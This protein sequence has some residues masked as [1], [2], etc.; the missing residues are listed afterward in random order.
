[1]NAIGGWKV[2]L[3]TQMGPQV[4]QLH[5]DAISGDH[6]TGRVVSAMGTDDFAGLVKANALQ[7]TMQ[8]KKPISIK[9]SFEVTVDGDTLS[10]KAKLGIFGKVPVS[11]ERLPAGS[12]VA[13][14][15]PPDVEADAVTADSVDPRFKDPYIDVN[16]LRN[17]PVPHRYVHGGFKN[18]DARFSF[19]FP[20]K[21][22][23]A[24]RF[25]HNTY[26]MAVSEDIG[27][28]PIAFE[29]STGNLGFTIDSGA[30]Y[31]QTNLGGRDRMPPA[32]LAIGAYRVNAAAA[33]YSRIVAA[34]LYGE[35]RPYGYLFGGSGGSYQ[36]MGAA[37]NTVGVW[38]GFVPFV[39]GSPNAIPS[40]LTIRTHALRVLR[41]R[42]KFPGIMDAISPGGSGDPYA[43]LN[44]EET[45]AL[46]E[47]TSLG[48]PPRGWWNHDTL[49]SGHLTQVAPLIPL[50][51][52]TYVDDFWTKPGYLGTDPA[53]SIRDARFHFD[54]RV[55][56]VIEGFPRQL[57]L[58]SV[59]DRDFAD[60]HLVML[61][62]EAAGKSTAIA[63][64]DG[65]TV[66]FAFAADQSVIN[67]IQAGDQVRIDNSWALAIQTY[68][69][70][71]VPTPDL[72][73]WNQYRNVDGTP[74]YPQRDILI[75]PIAAAGTAGSVPNGRIHGKMLML[76]T[77][78]DVD[79]I[80]WQADW[81]RSQVKAALGTA[82]EEN[83]ALWFIDHAQHDNPGTALA[84]AHTVS[85]EG[86]LQQAL[87]DVS[88]WVETGQRPAETRYE[89]VDS[90]VVVPDRAHERG[91]IQPV[92]HLFANGGARAD[93]A[94]NQP[95]AFSVA[96]EMPPNAG[97]IVAAEWDFEGRGNFTVVEPLD[98]PQA[99][100]HLS[101]THS[102][103]APGTYYAVLRATSQRQGNRHTPYSR[104]Q[105][106]ARARVEVAIA[107]PGG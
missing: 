94:V 76:D 62:G 49:T 86:A 44:D 82:F 89:V 97:T 10:G 4:M 78:L 66:G 50:L 34:E 90:Q 83:F 18:T 29:V 52:P 93:V 35:H 54:T 84:C 48:F 91:G 24:G 2:T 27:P 13:E 60:S 26:P 102:Y 25:F 11:G 58:A 56:R 105:N 95:I 98:T 1:M 19:Y 79:G 33:K 59:P 87:R 71:Q 46:K 40:M 100:L 73:A 69:R 72:Y 51:D 23:Y 55:A 6:F 3:A 74:V 80:P 61:S 14:A 106:I 9:V 17:E 39:I 99:L 5:I 47:A 28:F 70:H 45:A 101:A 30:Y 21:E 20:P 75:G 64:I 31:V 32:D 37:E 43:D 36:T 8:V 96:I 7:W 16:E 53:S 38:D 81:Y 12:P 88:A 41:Q 68:Q 104:I 65:K 42:N 92:I 77:L 63:T 67:S 107:L 15:P 22:R 57:E 85:Y 103:T